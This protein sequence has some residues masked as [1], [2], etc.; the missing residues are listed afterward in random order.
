MINMSINSINREY[1]DQVNHRRKQARISEINYLLGD[2]S[3][4]QLEN[5]HTYALNEFAEPNHEAVALEAIVKASR[6]THV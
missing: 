3:D 2:M 1:V 4:Q 5:V 6:E